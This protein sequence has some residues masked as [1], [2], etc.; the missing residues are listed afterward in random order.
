MRLIKRTEKIYKETKVKIRIT[1]G[2]TKEFTTNK[3]TRQGC[4]LS[5]L[6]FNMYM[7]DLE[8]KLEKRGIDLGKIRVWSLGYA[9][10]I[11]TTIGIMYR[12]NKTVSL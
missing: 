11:R 8:K 10:N 5:P 2:C 12:K 9:D 1:E 6:L 7:A 4:L 3:E